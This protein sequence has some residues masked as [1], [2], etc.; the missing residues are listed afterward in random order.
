MQIAFLIIF[1]IIIFLL[2]VPL[3]Y[4]FS[5]GYENYFW[6]N[7]NLSLLSL[8]GI[9][10]CWSSAPGKTLRMRLIAAGLS[11][12]I[13]PEKLG[14]R[15]NKK[16]MKGVGKGFPILFKI[17]RNL[18]RELIENIYALLRNILGMLKPGVLK[19]G[20][21]VGFAEPHYNGWLSALTG[22]LNDFYG[23]IKLDIEPVWEEEHC[24]FNFTIE[25]R[26][27]I[28]ILFFRIARFMLKRKTR[29]FLKI[30]RKEI[31][32]TA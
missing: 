29:E 15:K 6:V 13:N 22:A 31:A 2:L 9:K 23:A 1:A 27:I 25:G 21:K 12:G 3:K 32:S 18:D 16:Q 30:I 5:G 24:E 7:F 26:M 20:G 11:F 19:I 28:W 10:G 8:L 4:K 14:K 17:L